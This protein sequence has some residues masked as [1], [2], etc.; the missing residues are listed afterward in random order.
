M[1]DLSAPTR[2]IG[3]AGPILLRH[4]LLAV[5]GA[6]LSA[7]QPTVDESAPRVGEWGCRPVDSSSVDVNPPAFV[8]RPQDAAVHY[9]WQAARS[10]SFTVGVHHAQT[11]YPVHC[12]KAKFVG[13]LWYWRFR[14]ATAK[15]VSAWSKTRKFTIPAETPVFA[16]P[17]RATLVQR[18]PQTHPRLFIRPED[19]PG[20]RGR[21]K[22]AGK[23]AWAALVRRCEGYH[24]AEPSSEEP[25]KY[26]KDTVPGSEAWRKIWWGNRQATVAVLSAAADL[27]FVAA[28]GEGDE[29]SERAESD[30]HAALAREL[31]LAVA[32]WDPRG[33]TGFAYNDEAG[34]P[35]AYWFARTYTFL[36]AR[37]SPDERK[38]CQDVMGVRGRDI[39]RHLAP[40]HF[41]TPYNSHNNRAWHFLGEVGIAFFGEL[42]EAEEW[43]WFASRVFGAVYPV[44]GDMDG[45]WHEGLA[46]YLSY[47][48]RFTWWADVQKAAYGVDAYDKPF[49]AHV[50]DFVMYLQP[51]GTVG[52]GFGD[53][54]TSGERPRK[55]G[56]LLQRFASAADNGHWAWRAAQDGVPLDNSFIGWLRG[57][58]EVVKLAPPTDLPTSKLFR[59]TGVAVLNHT[60]LAAQDNVQVIFKSS[61][62]GTQSHG[63]EAQNSFLLY[64]FG[65]RLLIRSGR[66]DSYGSDHHKRWMWSTR[67]TNCITVDGKG[68]ARRSARARGRIAA[69]STSA[70]FDYVVGEAGEAYADALRFTR[71]VLFIK[72]DYIV[73]HDTLASEQPHKYEWWLHSIHE[74]QRQ[75]NQARIEGSKAS[76]LVKWLVPDPL[77][78]HSTD[79]CDP[80]P[81]SRIKLNQHH[82]T[83][84]TAQPQKDITFIT[85]V[86]P[87][88]TGAKVTLDAKVEAIEGGHRVRLD[89]AVT[90]DLLGDRTTATRGEKTFDS[91]SKPPTQSKSPK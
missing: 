9:Q 40:R 83:A 74:F 67:S 68:Q 44:W 47:L 61:P 25:P 41:F 28:V 30:K 72:P 39:Y 38:T 15:G 59:G 70:D 23:T 45:G 63:Y 81:R 11:T 24:E 22:G 79:K 80:P 19:L 85:V 13:G 88:R 71:R 32:K 16:L 46:Y 21:V 43:V 7:Q 91:K 64:A 75:G 5:L 17:D 10:A 62:F 52:G 57:R 27:A 51:P 77:T 20:L 29:G 65:E 86:R 37:L 35:Y 55:L 53:H 36:H 73:V 18:L 33:A 56:A 42:E 26:P 78:V 87:F 4:S 31:L 49:F 2:S 54:A 50:G 34:M 14:Y 60:L 82:L 6:A 1:P 76:C 8:C 3:V 66:R 90:V 58:A 84:S 12:P 69:F 48:D 89:G